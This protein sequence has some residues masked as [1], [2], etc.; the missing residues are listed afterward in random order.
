MSGAPM[1]EDGES[2]TMYL[3]GLLGRH[4]VGSAELAREIAELL[5]AGSY[6]EE[7]V[8]RQRPFTVEDAGDRWI[9]KGS[10]KADKENVPYGQLY[11]GIAILIVKKRD[12]Q[13]LQLA[14]PGHIKF[15]PEDAEVLRGYGLK[16]KQLQRQSPGRRRI[17]QLSEPTHL[18]WG[19]GIMARALT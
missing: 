17:E 8:A 19:R 6:G 5:I 11:S 18:T 15:S 1:A 10:Y 12:C 16:P 7:E 13:V 9:V 4:V 2:G 14:I 3:R